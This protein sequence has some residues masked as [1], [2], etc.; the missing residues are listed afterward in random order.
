MNKKI[1]I[2]SLIMISIALLIVGTSYAFIL[3]SKEGTKLI[4]MAADNIKLNYQENT[5]KKIDSE[6][7]L[8]ITD[9]QGKVL[10]DYFEFTIE[11][12]SATYDIPYIVSA[13]VL[14]QP[15]DKIPYDYIK[16]YLTEVVNNTEIPIS[17]ST[18]NELDVVYKNNI[19]EQVILSTNIPANTSN[20]SKVYRLR[21]WISEEAYFTAT[22]ETDF[23]VVSKSFEFKVNVYSDALELPAGLYDSDYNLVKTWSELESLGLTKEAIEKD[24]KMSNYD[25]NSSGSPYIV[26]NN[27]NLSGFLVLPNTITKI[28]NTSFRAISGLK[29][30]TLP[31]TITKIGSD[32]FA[33]TPITKITFP[34]SL[35]S[36]YDTAFFHSKLK[37]IYI[38]S[39]ITSIGT[40]AF[41]GC[42]DVESV[43]VDTANIVFDSR[44][45]CNAIIETSTDTLLFGFQNTTIPSTVKEIGDFAFADN[46]NITSVIL[47]DTVTSVGKSAFEYCRNL[48]SVKLP[49]NITSIKLG[50]FRQCDSLTSITIPSQ[51]T[52]IGIEA[53]HRA[54]IT[55]I[56]IPA[57]V[58]EIGIR[59][60]KECNSLEEATFEDTNSNWLEYQYD[61]ATGNSIIFTNNIAQN[62]NDLVN[63]YSLSTLKK[64][65]N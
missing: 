55:S 21:A 26:F 10:T 30:I 45:N 37:S 42:S 24:Y 51:V 25:L 61:V 18:Y 57:L 44:D 3:Y 13:K 43:V 15:E 53:F 20:Y 50:T 64:V 8:P 62:A 63:T 4:S 32:A 23:R 35:L 1:I 31:N 39:T 12:E 16:V 46:S 41:T 28:G 54:G 36:I 40:R 47:P 49:S 56:F 33:Y 27:N 2:V 6:D 19:I 7:S 14:T 5:L 22:G 17:L 29:G 11:G 59:A 38:P 60:F 65:T 34:A 48:T 58:T 52:E 9:E